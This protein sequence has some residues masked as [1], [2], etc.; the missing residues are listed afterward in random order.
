[1]LGVGLYTLEAVVVGHVASFQVVLD[2]FEPFD[3]SLVPLSLLWVID[4][5]FFLDQNDNLESLS[6]N[7]FPGVL[8]GIF[9]DI[10]CDDIVLCKM[11]LFVFAFAS[12]VLQVVL[13]V[14]GFL[15]LGGTGVVA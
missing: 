2:I 1:M 5:L 6:G 9:L 8:A 15:L 12:V 3:Y 4:L 10:P 7:I 14:F 13:F 11:E